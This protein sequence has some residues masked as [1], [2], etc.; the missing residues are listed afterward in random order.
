MKGCWN[1]ASAAGELVGWIHNSACSGSFEGEE[2][3]LWAERIV[4]STVFFKQAAWDGRSRSCCCWLLLLR[5]F[6]ALSGA[7]DW[8]QEDLLP[9]V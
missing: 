9:T 1:R 2:A 8:P 5:S 7:H 4:S 6:A 3:M